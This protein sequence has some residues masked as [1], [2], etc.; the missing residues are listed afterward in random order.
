MHHA[1]GGRKRTLEAA[2]LII[3]FYSFS[4]V[5]SFHKFGIRLVQFSLTFRR[6]FFRG[7][8]HCFRDRLF[9]RGRLG[10][11]GFALRLG[12]A[13][14]FHNGDSSDRVSHSEATAEI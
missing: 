10:A 14:N 5:R 13:I 2:T 3:H 4:L 9:L 6:W 11:L 8:L 7:F 1:T 12:S